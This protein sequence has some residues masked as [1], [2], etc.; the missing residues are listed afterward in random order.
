MEAVI[1]AYNGVEM[2]SVN[3]INNVE[4]SDGQAV[5]D[6]PHCLKQN[7]V[8]ETKSMMICFVNEGWK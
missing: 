2:K 4:E 3:T 5:D 8:Y 6:Q 7:D 1:Y